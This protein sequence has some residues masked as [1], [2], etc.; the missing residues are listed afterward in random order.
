MDAVKKRGHALQ[1]TLEDLRSDR[2]I[3]MAV[4]NKNEET[5]LFA[6]ENMTKDRDIVMTAVKKSEW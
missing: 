5:L 3:V 2:A 6:S 4:G 1:F